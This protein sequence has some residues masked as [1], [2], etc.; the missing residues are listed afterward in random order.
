MAACN[1]RIC[2]GRFDTKVF[3]AKNGRRAGQH[4][5]LSEQLI[6]WAIVSYGKIGSTTLANRAYGAYEQQMLRVSGRAWSAQPE[7]LSLLEDAI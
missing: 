3:F 1:S 4:V 6:R 7:T 2:D 5:T